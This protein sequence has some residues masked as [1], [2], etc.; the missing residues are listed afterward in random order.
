M[1]DFL[2]SSLH[3]CR[4]CAMA[5]VS[6]KDLPVH[7]AMLSLQLFFGLPLLRLPSTVPCSITLDRPSD[8]VTC[9]YHFS[10]RRFTVARR[11][12]YGPIC[13]TM[14]S[15]TCSF[16]TRSLRSLCPSISLPV[17]LHTSAMYVHCSCGLVAT[18][19]WKLF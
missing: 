12:S 6:A 14:V 9:P 2:V 11:S 17:S 7:S 19:G 4:L 5:W 15:R 3:S 8:L 18:D 10:L 1:M 13:F 16:V